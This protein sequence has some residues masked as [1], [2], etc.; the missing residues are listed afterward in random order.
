MIIRKKKQKKKLTLKSVAQKI[1]CDPDRLHIPHH[2]RVLANA[3]LEVLVVLEKASDE[4]S[5]NILKSQRE[6]DVERI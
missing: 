1:I 2:C 5:K 6:L 4:S 3:Y